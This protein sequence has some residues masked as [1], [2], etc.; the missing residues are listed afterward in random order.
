MHNVDQRT[1]NL[2]INDLEK[3]YEN[4]GDR[5]IIEK[6]KMLSNNV[7]FQ[8]ETNLY[9]ELIKSF[10]LFGNLNISAIRTIKS[11]CRVGNQTLILRKDTTIN[12]VYLVFGGIIKIYDSELR[13]VNEYSKNELFGMEYF[14]LF[15]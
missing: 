5:E 13:V 15:C 10:D 2:I 14:K 1:L 7:L 12:S 8:L 6:G 3:H 11:E 9:R 4:Y